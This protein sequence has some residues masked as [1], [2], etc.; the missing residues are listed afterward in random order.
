M[1]KL[2]AISIWLVIILLANLGWV[3]AVCERNGAIHMD[4]ERHPKPFK[5]PTQADIDLA[6]SLFSESDSSS[7][8]VAR[9][10]IIQKGADAYPILC[11]LYIFSAPV[12]VDGWFE[13]E[14]GAFHRSWPKEGE[15][16]VYDKVKANELLD[17]LILSLGPQLIPPIS[18]ALFDGDIIDRALSFHTFEVLDG[19]YEQSIPILIDALDILDPFGS[20]DV[21]VLHTASKILASYDVDVVLPALII[22]ITTR[23]DSIKIGAINTVSIFGRGAYDALPTLVDSLGNNNEWIRIAAIKAISSVGKG[24][25]A[26]KK[27]AK[28]L[29]DDPVEYVRQAAKAVLASNEG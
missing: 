2:N 13:D 21:P 18:K 12:V 14:I 29:L 15:I 6:V 1:L 20:N 19:K 27:Y 7:Y 10:A 16:Y 9:T 11:V 26:P 8:L 23:D 5:E 22:A 3:N 24:T 17:G 4:A 28:L 25:E